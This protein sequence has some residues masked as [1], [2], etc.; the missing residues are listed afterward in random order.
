MKKNYLLVCLLLI[1]SVSFAQ[2]A[3]SDNFLDK[4]TKELMNEFQTEVG[5]TVGYPEADWY[6]K[7]KR[8][9]N[10]AYL[11]TLWYE[12]FD[13]GFNGWTATNPNNNSMNWEWDTVYKTG[14][15]TGGLTAIQSTTGDNGFLSLP[16]DFNNSPRPATLVEAEAF[17][18]SPAIALSN[19]ASSVYLEFQQYFARCCFFAPMFWVEV[20]ADSLDWDT[21][22]DVERDVPL[23][24]LNQAPNNIQPHRINIS[25]VARDQDTIYVRFRASRAILW[26]WMIDDVTILEGPR[27]DLE[28]RDPTIT[29]V[30][31]SFA[32]TPTYYRIPYDLFTPVEMGGTLINGGWDT[33][34]NTSLTTDIT[35]IADINGNNAFNYVFG[36]TEA[37]PDDKIDPF[38]TGWIITEDTRYQPLD[39]GTFRVDYGIET[40]SVDQNPGSEEAELFFISTDTVFGKDDDAF[41]ISNGISPVDIGITGFSQGGHDGDAMGTMYIVESR[42]Q[43]NKVIP[44]SVTFYVSDNPANIGIEIIPAVWF[45]EEDT[46][47]IQDAWN[48]SDFLNL[49][50]K[51]LIMEGASYVVAA[52]DTNG[53]LTLPLDT[54][55]FAGLDSGQYIVGWEVLSGSTSARDVYFEVANDVTQSRIQPVFSSL[56]YHPNNHDP[57]LD[58]FII[59]HNR[60]TEFQPVIRWNLATLPIQ[61]SV[62]EIDN[63]KNQVFDVVPNPSNGEIKIN[64]M[65]EETATYR[66]NVRNLLGQVVY[67]DEITVNG[68]LS[69]RLDLSDLEKGLY[70]ITLENAVE[71]LQKKVIL[72]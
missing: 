12:D 61:T 21:I 59:S 70:F 47:S 17:V 28:F 65:V 60:N 64:L 8:P 51:G 35:R 42:S 63:S 6:Q 52:G 36:E 15:G 44:T 54:A 38:P 16:L 49:T 71:R 40:D 10:K 58:P 45:F 24:F 62:E 5:T 34:R 41:S 2:R 37:A 46:A 55:G 68:Q 3:N 39:Q 72:K 23:S 14:L 7:D 22:T 20:S 56:M 53:F 25:E 57:A 32:I 27:H 19:S 4:K 31:D 11:D 9:S 33:A 30:T 43:G 29:W 1:A 50:G 26:F 18:T 66:L 67:T 48:P 13:G 69:Q